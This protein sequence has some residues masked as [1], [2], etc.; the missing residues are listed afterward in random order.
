MSTRFTET[1]Y[2]AERIPVGY[3]HAPRNKINQCLLF[4]CLFIQSIIRAFSAGHST[5]TSHKHS[6][7]TIHAIQHV[8]DWE[9][10]RLTALT[11]KE[12]GRHSSMLSMLWWVKACVSKQEA[13]IQLLTNRN[14][15]IM[16]TTVFTW[17]T[18]G[19]QAKPGLSVKNW[20]INYW[21][22]APTL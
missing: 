19:F 7:T 9:Q 10:S 22:T 12:D 6:M 3:K 1:T 2:V 21:R 14:T 8:T 13:A 16:A 17:R 15:I 18:T 11:T 5:L 4:V 20:K